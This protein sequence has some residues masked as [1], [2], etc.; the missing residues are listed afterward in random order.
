MAR[1]KKVK[2]VK[3]A[4]SGYKLTLICFREKASSEGATIEEA[5]DSLNARNFKGRG[6]IQVTHNGITR[7]KIL[8]PSIVQ[9]FSNSMGL[10]R[11]IIIK[12][13]STLLR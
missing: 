13:L 9:R 10:S 6:I 2:E 3:V 7:D 12:N 1:P 11:Q 8:M 5:L 4:E